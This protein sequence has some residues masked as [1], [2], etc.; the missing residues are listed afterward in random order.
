MLNYG[1]ISELMN[2]SM[3][4]FEVA[5][6]MSLDSSFIFRNY[7]YSEVICITD[8]HIKFGEIMFIK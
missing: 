2:S 4:M 8:T 6:K 3:K 1:A 5:N 7:V